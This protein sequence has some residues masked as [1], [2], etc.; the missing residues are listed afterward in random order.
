MLE[1]SYLGEKVFAIRKTHN[2]RC[3]KTLRLCVLLWEDLLHFLLKLGICPAFVF[4]VAEKIMLCGE[5]LYIGQQTK[6][7]LFENLFKSYQLRLA[8]YM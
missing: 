3:A 2:I 6:L 4:G 5:Y 8:V 7:I 1:I